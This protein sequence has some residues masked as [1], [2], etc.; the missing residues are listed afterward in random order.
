MVKKIFEAEPKK[1]LLKYKGKTY[2]D[3]SYGRKMLKKAKEENANKKPIKPPLPP[4][5]KNLVRGK[6]GKLKQFTNN[7]YGEKM[8]EKFIAK[9]IS[10]AIQNKVPKSGLT[11]TEKGDSLGLYKQLKSVLDK[12]NKKTA[13]ISSFAKTNNARAITDAK[14]KGNKMILKIKNKDG[15]SES[16]T[17]ILLQKKEPVKPVKKAPVKKA[18]VKKEPV[19]KAPVKKEPV[20]KAPVKKAN[21]VAKANGKAPAKKQQITKEDVLREEEEEVDGSLEQLI[22][23][24]PMKTTASLKHSLGIFG[25]DIATFSRYDA[26]II[27]ELK[28]RQVKIGKKYTDNYTR[29]LNK[30]MHQMYSSGSKKDKVDAKPQPKKSLAPKKSI[31]QLGLE[32]QE[33]AYQKRLKIQKE[34]QLKG[35]REGYT[36]EYRQ[37]EAYQF[38][39]FDLLDSLRKKNLPTIQKINKLLDSEKYKKAVENIRQKAIKKSSKGFRSDIDPD[40]HYRTGFNSLD[41]YNEYYEE[42]YGAQTLKTPKEIKEEY[43]GKLNAYE[44]KFNEFLKEGEQ[45]EERIMPMDKQLSSVIKDLFNLVQVKENVEKVKK[46][47]SGYYQSESKGVL[48]PNITL[49]KFYGGSFKITTQ[50]NDSIDEYTFDEKGKLIDQIKNFKKKSRSRTYLRG[51]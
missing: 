22:K 24:L 6:D 26:K 7:P 43:E 3:N 31:V 33:K 25:G 2:S 20:K 23:N 8:K 12:N 10:K 38:E 35:K 44:K 9:Q 21:E 29:Y 27:E 46:I 49:E 39:V 19:K 4:Y 51:L 45:K 42:L 17:Y 41:S 18:P 30:K 15:K 40:Y 48:S 5:A 11:S 14:I 32:E 47:K 16:K 36:E 28:R 34:E 50:L 1:R 13:G 37:S